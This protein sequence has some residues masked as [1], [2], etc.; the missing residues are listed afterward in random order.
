MY[1]QKELLSSRCEKV[2]LGL[3]IKKMTFTNPDIYTLHC[4]TH[5]RYSNADY[6]KTM[7]GPEKS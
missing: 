7:N 2:K 1:A 3:K 6:S 4:I 5:I